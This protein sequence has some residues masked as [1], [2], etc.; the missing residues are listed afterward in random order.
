LKGCFV[1]VKGRIGGSDRTRKVVCK[2]GTLPLQKKTACIDFY[3]AEAL[4]IYGLCSVK[5]W[6]YY[7]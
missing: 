4:T 1:Q 2:V 7:S 3:I 6:A 5:V